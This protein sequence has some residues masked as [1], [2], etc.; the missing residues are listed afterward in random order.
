M[1]EMYEP[2]RA[3]GALAKAAKLRGQYA[4][5]VQVIQRS[6]DLSKEEKRQR[7]ALLHEAHQR[8]MQ[9]CRLVRHQAHR[10]ALRQVVLDL[11]ADDASPSAM[12]LDIYQRAVLELLDKP[13]AQLTRAYD[14]AELI[15]HSL[16]MRAA[17]VAAL[18]R[19][20]PTPNDAAENLL[21]RF[22]TATE[23]DGN[24]G[25]RSRF[26]KAAGAW[27]RLKELEAW[28]RQ[29]HL[30]AEAIFSVAA[31]PPKPE[32]P[33]PVSPMDAARDDVAALYSRDNGQATASAGGSGGQPPAAS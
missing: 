26:P 18:Q 25:T 29:E 6:R 11:A 14:V 7:L 22:A 9:E 5:A 15:G 19:R 16:G 3:R 13:L 4:N 32:D 24:G 2:P 1:P 23:S 20:G 31:T 28:T 27:Q 30:A 10:D 8:G 21:E 33:E 12:R 17:A